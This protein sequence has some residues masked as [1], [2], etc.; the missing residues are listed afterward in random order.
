M[1][2]IT[3][4]FRLF[5]LLLPFSAYAQDSLLTQIKTIAQD[6]KGK[7]SVAVLSLEDKKSISYYGDE[8]CVMQ[9]VFKFPIALAIL[10]KVDKGEFSLQH[11]IHITPKEMI[12][13]TWSPVRDSFP[14]GNVNITFENLLKYM[15]CV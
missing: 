14:D 3:V 6:A 7:V 2:K 11:K 8:P 10:D 9:S 5:I 12:K 4:L 1:P 13:D 15:R